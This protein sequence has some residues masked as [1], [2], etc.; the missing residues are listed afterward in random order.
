MAPTVID[1][2]QEPIDAGKL[3]AGVLDPCAGGTAVFIGTTRTPPGERRVEHLVY[4]AYIPMALGMMRSIA[5]SARAR[6]QLAGVCAVH[7]IG[8]VAVGEASIVVAASA[9]HRVEAFEAC[10]HIVDAVKKDAP[11][12][13]KEVFADGE[14]WVGP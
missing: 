13:K 14:A 7:R 12:W 8:R 11:I 4:E 6:W 10:R 9:A 2:V 3:I 1:I 5:E